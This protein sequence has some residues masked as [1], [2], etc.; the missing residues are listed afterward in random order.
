MLFQE[1]SDNCLDHSGKAEEGD[2]WTLDTR[3][4]TG[5]INKT[6]E[7]L[8]NFGEGEYHLQRMKF[9][10]VTCQYTESNW[11]GGGSGGMR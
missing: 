4:T 10:I 1:K 3:H 8:D 6:F 9:V 7:F 11:G 2:N 5:R